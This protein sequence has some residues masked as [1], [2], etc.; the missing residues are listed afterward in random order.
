MRLRLDSM[1]GFSIR[2]P[3]PTSRST[4]AWLLLAVL[5]PA[6]GV[7][8]CSKDDDPV[9]PPP[10]LRQARQI[11]AEFAQEAESLVEGNN[12]FAVDLYHQLSG[13][14]GNLI[15]SPFSASSMLA[16][17]WAGARG[18]TE[19]QMQTTL[20]FPYSQDLLHQTF[21][22]LQRSL[23]TGMS[24]SLYELRIANRL[25][26]QNGYPWLEPFLETTR[27]EY[28]AELAEVDFEMDA[29]GATETINNWVNEKTA[30]KIPE[31]L[32]PGLVNS[33]T[34]LVLTNAIYFK[35]DWVS[36]FDPEDTRD[37]DFRTAGGQ[38]ISVPM[39][40]QKQEFLHGALQ[41]A[42]IVEL[43]YVGQDISMV[44]ILPNAVDGL[45]A[46]EASL[47]A[48]DL[49]SWLETLQETEVDLWLP[50]FTFSK[51]T[52]LKPV[53]IAMGMTSAFDPLTA[54]L[55]GMALGGQPGVNDL[56]VHFVVQ[57][58]FILVNEEGTEAAAATAGGVGPTSYE[59]AVFHADH[60]FL[61]LIRDR[62][63]GSILFMGR[64]V[65][66]AA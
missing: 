45:P 18:E 53:L 39:M 10:D 58:A 6:L 8:G 63:T 55:T 26:G 37:E 47:T 32:A 24:A 59:P 31:L 44:V 19:S 51:R 9:S 61:F 35:G 30:G 4:R 33:L 64:V 42:Q 2:S 50:R 49:T 23:D 3:R 60:P 34:R 7:A 66:P 13:Q 20:R 11:P 57:E 12:A 29:G 52:D 22:A 62:V 40:R 65:N 5:L 43:P 17:L 54:D 1:S 27:L 14:D 56:Y 41:D 25:W 16:M 15:L 36:Q 28:D 46:L 21:G 48:E 38:S